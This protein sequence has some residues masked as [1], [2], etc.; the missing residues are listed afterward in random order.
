MPIAVV[1]IGGNSL[2]RPGER[3]TLEEQRANLPVTC[4]GIAAVM[5]AGYRVVVTH[6]NGPQVGDA[7][8]RS[9]LAASQVPPLTLDACVAETQATIGY[10]L[11][12]MLQETLQRHGLRRPVVTIVTEVLVSRRD[13]AWRNPTKPVGPFYT[14]EEAEGRRAALGWTMA[15]D[16]RRGYRRLV[17]SPEPKEIMELAAIQAALA[18]DVLVIACGGGGIPVVFKRERLVGVEAVIDKDRASSLLAWE[19]EAELFLIS[20]GVE[21]VALH[22]GTP[23]ERA[24]ESL[25]AA[26]ARR[27]LREGQF[28]PGSMGPKIEAALAYLERG[29]RLAIITSPERI[30]EALHGLAGTRLTPAAEPAVLPRAPRAA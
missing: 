20:T 28:P 13:P 30:P 10:L 15:E 27:Y 2:V 24:I 26:E 18:N 4:E 23:R 11:Q 29:G 17:P 5:A 7:L 12:Q 9:E 21:Q 22:Y 19:L 8:L 3:G 14:R 1:A 6:G 25:T 16:A